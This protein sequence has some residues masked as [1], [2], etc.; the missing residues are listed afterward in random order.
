MDIMEKLTI[1]TDSAKYDVACTSSGGK[2]RQGKGMG[3]IVPAGVCHSFTQDGRCVSLLKVLQTN[4][5]IYNCKYCVNQCS[6]DVP[7]ATFTPRELADLTM[8]FYRRNYIEGLF[9]S[10]GV[11]K[12][13]DY[14]ME[15]M[16]KTLEILRL[17]YGFKGYIH[18]KAIPG[19]DPLLVNKMAY[20]A[21]R[22]SI[23]IELPSEKSLKALAPNKEKKA[24]LSPMKQIAQGGKEHTKALSLYRHAPLYAPAGQSTQMI[25]GA[26]GESDYQMI[27]LAKGLYKS[28]GLKRVFY[29]AYIPAVEDTLLP[30]VDTKPPLLREHRLY[31][32]DWLMRFYQFD[33]EEIL[34][35]QNPNF[36][37]LLDPKANWALYNLHLFPMDVQK[38]DLYQLLR[39]PGIGPKSARRIV[40][41][42][43]E[44][45]LT[46][47][48]LKKMGVV[49]KRAK[50][51]VI[52][53]DQPTG[54]SSHPGQT[55]K[56]LM[57]PKAFTFGQEQL[58]MFTHF[59][60]MESILQEKTREKQLY[61]AKEALTWQATPY[62]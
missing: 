40:I 10:S 38:A 18:S 14:T 8:G 52:T 22:M 50:Y 19:A 1:L 4:V 6:N 62:H 9:V 21:D 61:A 25:I 59:S 41:A 15:Q 37:P 39:V 42:R 60:P 31:Q 48:S 5:C 24:I 58:S 33:A 12:N 47:D 11:I 28:Y 55:A 53:A 7:R 23:N 3:S 34:S 30:S 35:E 44:S 27:R 13:P 2:Q 51:F 45:V 56:A 26:S 29:S 36:N 43:R 17:E 46:M 57:D 32:A 49:V 16:I 54:F 20:L